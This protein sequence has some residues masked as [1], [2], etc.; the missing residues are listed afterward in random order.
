MYSA[1]EIAKYIIT[2]CSKDNNPLSNLQLQKIMYYVQREFLQK[3]YV[4]LF[5]DDFYAWKFGPVLEEV[6]YNYCNRGASKIQE[7]YKNIGLTKEEKEMVDNVV[8]AKRQLNPWDMVE[9]THK[10][11]G[12]WDIVYNYG[13]GLG[14]VIEK[15]LIKDRG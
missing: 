9:E 4:P 8:N 1:M 12:A 15:Q 10:Q 6:Y 14:K 2:K 13:N 3:K 5:N 11:G 7:S